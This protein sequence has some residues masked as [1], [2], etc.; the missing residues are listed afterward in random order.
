M[1]FSTL[2]SDPFTSIIEL[3]KQRVEVTQN[4]EKTPVSIAEAKRKFN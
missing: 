3:E 4:S 1:I 2:G